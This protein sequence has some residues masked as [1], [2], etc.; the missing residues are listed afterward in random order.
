MAKT[1]TYTIPSPEEMLESGLHIGHTRRRWHP[2]MAPFIY[3]QKNKIHIFDLYKTQPLLEEACSFLYEVA[4]RGGKIIFLGTKIQSQDI[5]ESQAKE[6]GALYITKRWLGGT[7]SNFAEVKAIREKLKFLMQGQKDGSFEKY[8]KKERLL[9]ARKV[10]KLRSYHEGVLSLDSMPD[11]LFVVDAKREKTAIKEA[12]EAGVPVVAL[13]DSNTNP[14]G[15]K[16][17][18]PGN[19]DAIKA[20][21]IVVKAVS[22]AVL[23]GYRDAKAVSKEPESKDVVADKVGVEKEVVKAEKI[24]KQRKN[25]EPA[26]KIKVAVKLEEVK[27]RGRPKRVKS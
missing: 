13:I 10:N 26:K 11:A 5:V 1:Q 21:D 9:I 20:I 8:T 2:K 7:L 27:K 18:I 4:K 16:Y 15:I 17:P 19:D 22:N 24:I 3:T 6:S 23:L 25:K 14:N 12:I